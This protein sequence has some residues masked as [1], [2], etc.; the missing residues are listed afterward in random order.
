[1]TRMEH[2]RERR[3]ELVRSRGGD[4]GDTGPPANHK[5]GPLKA[6]MREHRLLMEQAITRKQFRTAAQHAR[7]LAKVLDE[8]AGPPAS[9]ATDGALPRQL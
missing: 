6:S 5:V 8:L 1:M 4:R 2:E 3:A 7:R 9:R